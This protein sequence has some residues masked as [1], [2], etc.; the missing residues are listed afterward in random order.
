MKLLARA[1]QDRADVVGPLLRDLDVALQVHVH[2][3]GDG[4]V[5]VEG[6]ESLHG[7]DGVVRE[8]D[9]RLI[10]FLTPAERGL[11]RL[12]LKCSGV[13][14]KIALVLLSDHNVNTLAEVIACQDA[15]TLT[16]SKGVGMRMAEKVIVELKDKVL[17]WQAEYG[18]QE[19]VP[20]SGRSGGQSEHDAVA[21]LQ[22][23]GYSLRDAE[24]A[25]AA[26]VASHED[27]AA[28]Q[29]LVKLALRHLTRNTEQA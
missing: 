16:A 15:R 10:G 2:E 26:V 28:S 22:V 1:E 23:L 4:E 19:W 25:V 21:A 17:A 18:N 9:Q 12:L 24:K 14:I 27:D 5:G 11:F 29:D 20:A 13:G 6:L 8:D 7:A 3:A